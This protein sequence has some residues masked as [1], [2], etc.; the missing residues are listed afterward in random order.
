MSAR[1]GSVIAQALL[2]GVGGSMLLPWQQSNI[3]AEPAP[4][5]LQGIDVSEG[6]L[7][8][9]AAVLTIGFIQVGLRPAWMGAGFIVAVLGRQ[10]FAG[11]G[12]PGI[13]AI[14]GLLFAAIAGAI[15]LNDLVRG[16]QGGP[17]P[18]TRA[19]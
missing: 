12:D 11:T 6:T 9:V 1:L 17:L 3:G 7:V 19:G 15:L 18:S 10:V 5:Q 14:L 2:V 16:V 13:G 4:E 8:L